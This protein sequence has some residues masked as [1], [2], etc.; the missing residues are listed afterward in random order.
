MRASYNRRL[1][2]TTKCQNPNF[3]RK[4]TVIVLMLEACYSGNFVTH[5]RQQK[6]TL[7]TSW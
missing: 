6:L 5:F 4:E 3:K 2:K 7:V 1:V